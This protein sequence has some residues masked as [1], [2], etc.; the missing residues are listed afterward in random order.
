MSPSAQCPFQVTLTDG[1]KLC[2]DPWFV[3]CIWRS[4]AMVQRFCEGD[5]RK[6]PFYQIHGLPESAWKAC[7]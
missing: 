2:F 7:A 1:Q 4:P 6:C 5:F 3:R